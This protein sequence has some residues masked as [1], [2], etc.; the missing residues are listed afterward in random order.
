[1]Y[2]SILFQITLFKLLKDDIARLF[3]IV[4]DSFVFSISWCN[5]KNLDLALRMM[6]QTTV[7]APL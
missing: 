3:N 6:T 2:L 1:M 4:K 5:D 7:R